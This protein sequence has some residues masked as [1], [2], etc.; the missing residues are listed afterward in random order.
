MSGGL[1]KSIWPTRCSLCNC[2][3]LAADTF[4]EQMSQ[5]IRWASVSQ[6]DQDG[7]HCANARYS[8]LIRWNWTLL[9]SLQI[10]NAW[11]TLNPNIFTNWNTFKTR[12]LQC[13]QYIFYQKLVMHN[14]YKAFGK[15][16]PNILKDWNWFEVHPTQC[17]VIIL[18]KRQCTVH[19]AQLFLFKRHGKWSFWFC[20]CFLTATTLRFCNCTIHQI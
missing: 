12:C 17:T 13:T 10:V 20:E 14:L 8:L 16:S 6:P 18:F 9:L 4:D 2:K 5:N 11:N 3:I 15:L 19:S 7:A 1:P